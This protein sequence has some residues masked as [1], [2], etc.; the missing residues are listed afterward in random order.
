MEPTPEERPQAPSSDNGD[1]TGLKP[2]TWGLLLVFSA[3]TLASLLFAA[4]PSPSFC[5]SCH[6]MR[7]EHAAWR[8]STHKEIPCNRCHQ[9]PGFLGQARQRTRILGMVFAKTTG[10]YQKPISGRIPNNVCLSCHSDIVNKTV[11]ANSFRMSHKETIKNGWNCGMCHNAVVHKG[12]NQLANTGSMEKCLKCHT[13]EGATTDCRDCHTE[14]PDRAKLKQS[15]W[16]I[17]HGQNWR[18]THSVLDRTICPVCH[19]ELFCSRCHRLQDLPHPD[20]WMNIHGPLAVKTREK[21]YQCHWKSFCENCHKVEMPHPADWLP[22]HPGVAKTTEDKRCLRCHMQ[23]GCNECHQRHVHPLS[24]EK[25]DK[26]QDM[27]G[28]GPWPG[29]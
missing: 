17:A 8:Q 3:V 20:G 4:A 16:L 7:S 1:W 12:P 28:K 26:I 6:E 11:T 23:R 19:S 15:P 21:C 13:D 25:F 10:V 14:Q 2:A 22:T 24:I 29:L 5:S 18:R 9:D 27:N